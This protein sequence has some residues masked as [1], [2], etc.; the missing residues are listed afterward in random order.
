MKTLDIP[1]VVMVCFHSCA[2]RQNATKAR[3]PFYGS[4]T[5]RDPVKIAQEVPCPTRPSLCAHER[6]GLSHRR[7]WLAS[8]PAP[9]PA[10]SHSCGL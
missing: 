2:S 8:R 6:R 1:M 10:A 9:P 4:Y 3:I 7:R 5:D